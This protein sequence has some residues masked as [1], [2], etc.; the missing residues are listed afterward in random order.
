M[1][2]DGGDL[3]G[4]PLQPDAGE[5]VEP[6][7]FH[8]ERGERRDQRLFEVADVLLDVAA[9]AVEVEDRVTDELARPVERRLAA[10]V[11]LDDLD[12]RALR[13]VELLRLVRAPAERDDRR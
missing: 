6:R 13:D 2:A 11:G 7:P 5:A 9:V 12:F 10:A 8:A 4:R 1:H 3:P